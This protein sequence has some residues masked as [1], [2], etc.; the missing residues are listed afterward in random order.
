M[1]SVRHWRHTR[2]ASGTVTQTSNTEA[3]TSFNDMV[4][5]NTNKFTSRIGMIIASLNVNSLLSH[6][7]DIALLVKEQGIHFLALNETKIDKNC[8][9]ESL[10]IEGYKIE[11]LDRNRNGGSV[12]FYIRDSF[13]YIFRKDAPTSS[14]EIICAEIT[15]PKSSPFCILSWYRPP[16][17]K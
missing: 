9:S 1:P 4:S 11:R 12:A 16:L 14:L 5:R 17:A 15:P 13:K 2:S 10:Y 3:Y 6:H 7:D 8:S